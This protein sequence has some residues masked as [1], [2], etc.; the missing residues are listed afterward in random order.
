MQR[1]APVVRLYPSDEY[2]PSS[3]EW[4][5]QRTHMRFHHSDCSDCQIPQQGRGHHVQRHD[6]IAPQQERLAMV[7]PQRLL[8]V[9]GPADGDGA[10]VASMYFSAHDREGLW[11]SA[12]QLLYAS[13]RPVA[14]SAW[15]SHASYPWPQT[16]NR[17]FPKP[18]DYTANGG[19]TWG[20]PDLAGEPGR[21]G[22]GLERQSVAEFQREL[23]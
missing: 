23:G 13:G 7:Q 15:H 14:Y 4:Y 8:A 20:L 11:Y 17:S 3:A 16:W 18:A 19:P 22:S 10:A 6:A 5:L 9:L 12:N 2:R 21:E 1:F